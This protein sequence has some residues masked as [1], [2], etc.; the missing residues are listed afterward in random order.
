MAARE[1]PTVPGHGG[2]LVIKAQTMRIAIIHDW[3]YVLGGAEKVLSAMVRC[4]PSADL[5]TLF[6]TLSPQDRA[7]AGLPTSRSTFLQH[8]PAISSKHRSYLPLMPLAI[9]QLDLSGYDVVLSSSHAVA[10]GVI[11]GAD[12]L[13]ISY[14]HSPMRYAWDLQHQC[15]REARLDHGVAGWL[16]R[17]ILFKMRLWD[18]RTAA[19]VDAYLANS[20]YVGRRIRKVYG[21]SSTVIH[22]PVD[23][24]TELPP[25]ASTANTK[26]G[27]GFYLAASRLVPYKNIMA[28]V[29]AFAAMPSKRLVVAGTGPELSRL[30]AF[31]APNVQFVGFVPDQDLRHLMRAAKAFVFAADE[32][33]GIVPVEVQGEGTPVIALGRGGLRETVM[34]QGPL[35][36][37]MFFER[38]ESACIVAAVEAF[39]RSSHLFSRAACHANALQFG[40]ARFEHELTNFVHGRYELFKRRIS[41]SLASSAQQASAVQ[42]R[43]PA[44]SEQSDFID[45]ELSA[46]KA[47]KSSLSAE[48]A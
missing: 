1:M 45:A 6:D 7:K 40:S 34:T 44:T 46:S 38:P 25:P 30:K 32:D 4:F 8:M 39:E 5:F 23:V 27:S 2:A 48:A 20:H 10:K 22:P 26:H 3:L 47:Y 9:E 11:T 31:G 12:Q 28:I 24:P 19:G 36:T 33:F 37:G 18:T 13:H 41:A 21:R 42:S 16:A 35:P 43:W 29:Q 14:V 17:Y 15:L